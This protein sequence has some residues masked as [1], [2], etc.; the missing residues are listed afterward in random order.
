MRIQTC[1]S[2]KALRGSSKIYQFER[3]EKEVDIKFPQ[4]GVLSN[5][6][7]TVVCLKRMAKKT[8]SHTFWR[9]LRNRAVIQRAPKTGPIIIVSI[10]EVKIFMDNVASHILEKNR[11]SNTFFLSHFSSTFHLPHQQSWIHVHLT[12]DTKFLVTLTLH[13]IYLLLQQWMNGYKPKTGTTV[14]NSDHTHNVTLTCRTAQSSSSSTS[15]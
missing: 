6:T 4:S 13:G 9:L 2:H 1:G 15:S 5:N 7:S 12:P 3:L 11:V 8:Q 10:S 14:W